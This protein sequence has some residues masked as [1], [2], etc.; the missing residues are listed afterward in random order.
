MR[1]C[2]QETYGCFVMGASDLLI[3]VLLVEYP[4]GLGLL[5]RSFWLPLQWRIMMLWLLP[6]LKWVLQ[7]QI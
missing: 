5:W 2:M 4:Q 3:L 6:F 1:T 7:G